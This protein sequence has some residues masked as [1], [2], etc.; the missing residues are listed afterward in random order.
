MKSFRKVIPVILSGG[1]GT[2]LWPMS[3][4]SYPKQFLNLSSDELSLIQETAIRVS[5]KNKFEQPIF[6]CNSEHRFLVAEQIRNIGLEKS[7]IILEPSVRNTAPALTMAAIYIREI[8]KDALIL[9][10]PSDHIIKDKEAFLEGVSRAVKT[11]DN[12]YLVTFGIKPEY[13]ETGYGY[14]KYGKTIDKKHSS[15]KVDE[16]IEKPNLNDA[17]KY[18]KSG[19]YAWNS[20]IFMFPVN[21]YLSEMEKYQPEIIVACD[22]SN[23][24]K[25]HDHDFIRIDKKTYNLAPKISIDYAVM[26]KT[27][28]A[29][30]ISLE[31]GWADAGSWESLWKISNKD[32]N[33]NVIKGLSYNFNTK[34]SYIESSEGPVIATIGLEDLVIIST[35]D[36]VL[37]AHKEQTQNVKK[38]VDDIRK[39][40]TNLIEN[41]RQI[42]RPWGYYDCIDS[43]DR[44]QAKRIHIKPGAKISLQVHY[45][46]AE[47]W[48]VVRGAAKVICG[49]EEHFISENQ[50]IYIP[51]GVVHC[52]ENPGKI[53]LEIIEVQS[54]SYLGEDDI[55]RFEDNYGRASNN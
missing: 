7:A 38:L 52:I 40:N 44:Y 48:V 22:K 2:R 31:C 8:Y 55:V 51:C 5:D 41:H 3:R 36:C 47:H 17:E 18:L 34:N 12:Q 32:E 35:K 29:A 16:F 54:G 21:L 49:N 45:H 33:G 30:V 9:V 13:Q 39:N 43:G 6:V 20:G 23:K 24:T 19:L 46:R 4:G 25:T 15:F 37:V 26:E 14:I 42:Y 50:S 28:K 11:A 1:I 27:D 10:L 53:E